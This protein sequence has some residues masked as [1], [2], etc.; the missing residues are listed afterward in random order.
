M[1]KMGTTTYWYLPTTVMHEIGHTVGMG[2]LYSD[3]LGDRYQDYLM[4]PSKDP[5][6]RPH[7]YF[8]VPDLDL[9]YLKQ[10]YRVYGHR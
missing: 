4:G 2:D 3:L 8:G 9:A 6:G 10:I 7:I 5:T 1:K